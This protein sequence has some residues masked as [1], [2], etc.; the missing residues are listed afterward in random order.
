MACICSDG[1]PLS[2]TLIF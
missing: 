2:P 1:K